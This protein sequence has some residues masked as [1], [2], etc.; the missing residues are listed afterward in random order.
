MDKA[1]TKTREIKRYNKNL[2][3]NEALITKPFERKAW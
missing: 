2:A 3:L 1:E